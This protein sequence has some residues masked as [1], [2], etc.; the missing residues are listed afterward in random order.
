MSSLEEILRRYGENKLLV[1][2]V[3]AVIGAVL[4][5]ALPSMARG[6]AVALRAIGGLMGGRLAYAAFQ[7][8]YLDWIVTEQSE[9]KLTGVVSA[10]EAKK[11]KLEQVFVSLHIDR[12]RALGESPA[13]E[14]LLAPYARNWLDVEEMLAICCASAADSE[15]DHLNHLRRGVRRHHRRLVLRKLFPF[16]SMSSDGVERDEVAKWLGQ[17]GRLLNEY[18]PDVMLRRAL[19]AHDRIA[20]LGAPGAGKSTLLQYIALAYARQRAGDRKLREKGVLRRRLGART[21]RLPIIVRL[22]SIAAILAERTRSGATASLVEALPRIL[23]PDLQSNA[24]AQKFFASQLSRGNC[25]VLLDGLD[26]VPSE[27]EFTTVVKAVESCALTFR[28]N[29]FVIT[30]RIAGWRGGVAGE[31]ELFYVNELNDKQISTFIDTWYS[32]VE[33]NSVVGPLQDEGAA[34]RSARERRAVNRAAELKATLRDNPG[35]RRL[36]ANPM[37]LSIVALVHRSL[38][39]LPRE[40]AKLYAQCSK[41]LLE[42]W[43]VSRGVRVDD[44]NLK[45]PQKERIMQRLAFAMH[46]GEI[47][48]PGGGREA[49]WIAVENL[50]G[51][52]LPSIGKEGAE[53]S[54]LLRMLVD[55]SGILLERQR[56][57]LSFAHLTFQEYFAAKH[58]ASDQ[59]TG[60]ARNFLLEPARLASDWWRE[61]ILLYAGLLPDTGDFLARMHV[62]VGEADLCQQGTRLTGLCLS[63][64]VSVGDADLRKAI[65]SDLY[66]IRTQGE[67]LSR[68]LSVEEQEYLLVWPRQ[69][70]W[71]LSAATAFSSRVGTDELRRSLKQALC[72]T[73][74]AVRTAALNIIATAPADLRCPEAK[75]QILQALSS[76]D[77]T[78]RR[79][80][81]RA[82]VRMLGWEADEGLVR[83]VR[84]TLE[85]QV[86][87]VSDAIVEQLLNAT[88]NVTSLIVEGLY[89]DILQSGVR[90]GAELIVRSLSSKRVTER[91]EFMRLLAPRIVSN[92]GLG[93]KVFLQTIAGIA[94]PE[95]D[96]VELVNAIAPAIHIADASERAMIVTAVLACVPQHRDVKV[97]EIAKTWAGDHNRNVRLAALALVDRRRDGRYSGSA[98]ASLV[99]LLS[100]SDSDV[101]ELAAKVLPHVRACAVRNER[102]K[103]LLA[104][105]TDR[106]SGV[107]A[108]AIEAL[109]VLAHS[110]VRDQAVEMCR[111]A[112]ADKVARVR[113]SA[114]EAMWKLTGKR[115]SPA[116][117][118]ALQSALEPTAL[119]PTWI[120]RKRP[121]WLSDSDLA[122]VARIAADIGAPQL[123]EGVF[124]AVRKQLRGGMLRG[125]VFREMEYQVEDSSLL[126][127]MIHQDGILV[128]FIR[129]MSE[130]RAVLGGEVVDAL[131][132]GIR[133]FGA[134]I[135]SKALVGFM[136][137]SDPIARLAGVELYSVLGDSSDDGAFEAYRALLVDKEP[138][139]RAFAA[140]EASRIARTSARDVTRELRR[141][142]SDSDVMVREAAW[143]SLCSLAQPTISRK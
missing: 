75:E 28:E 139:L 62:G 22:S 141:L 9:L 43:D 30:S 4:T 81:A 5:K 51:T 113:I 48:E 66:H 101:R 74:T 137:D 69:A 83:S 35:I 114:A 38:A 53:A 132:L 63:E 21:W 122:R 76:D 93:L 29:Q 23:P 95:F 1:A 92:G 88:P 8:R 82:A 31:F 112:M 33:R 143:R 140:T 44:T 58:L 68:Q 67:V 72:S 14:P 3:S 7:Q 37:L 11:P 77:W 99:A 25:I 110:S 142:L 40:R 105:C 119:V 100:D 134:G 115:D 111:T 104:L 133:R 52:M 15:Q 86:S 20:I 64:A 41:I 103:L 61:V 27:G 108:N 42:Q 128:P 18:L 46:T 47:G 98:V 123:F 45:L 102:Y 73:E 118:A 6:V 55:R 89:A 80:G 107:R 94:T 138:W 57:T 131:R 65:V 87:F 79:A 126:S 96:G 12:S 129:G 34:A 135:G 16:A 70:V 59:A 56:G 50:L 19:T 17:N 32:A 124:G 85:S 2:V 106:N 116:I 54:H 125:Y 109:P 136:I 121:P 36:A 71:F 117:E 13:G 39:T 120:L 91:I 10:D 60:S 49:P 97:G 78:E 24:V 130:G 84:A 127:I 26:E 90:G